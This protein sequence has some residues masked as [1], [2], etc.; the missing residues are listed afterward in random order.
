MKYDPRHLVQFAAIIEEGSFS[1]AAER[2]GTTQ[3]ALSSMVKTLETRAGLDL[4]ARRRRPVTPT[5]LGAELARMGQGVRSLIH[6]AERTTDDV[7]RGQVGVIRVAA[8]SFFCEFVLSEMVTDFW[9]SHPKASFDIQT[10]YQPELYELVAGNEVDM[11]FGPIQSD[12]P[13][14]QLEMQLLL[15]LEHGVLCRAGHPL[16][17]QEEVSVSDL[18]EA[19]W[20]T[21][22]TRSTLFQTMQAALASMGI[23]GISNAL[24]CSSASTLIEL[25]KTTD[26]LTILP[27]VVVL[28]LIRSG[29]LVRL[30]FPGT[31]PGIPFGLI[32]HRHAKLTPLENAFLAHADAGLKK[33]TAFIEGG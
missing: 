12:H 25:L 14:R 27:P 9:E 31:L 6:E 20:I 21:H 5:P 4:L 30:N 13:N 29:A 2:L 28:P 23:S 1:L 17:A 22:A 3:P 11:A 19:S 16:L 10:G 26:C 18:Q 15:T 33:M 8:P 24:R 32:T 7:R